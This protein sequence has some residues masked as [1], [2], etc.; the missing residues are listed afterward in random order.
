[1]AHRAPLTMDGRERVRRQFT[2]GGADRPPLIVF[3]TEF[4]ARLEQVDPDALWQ[5]A[6]LLTRTLLGLHSLFGLD[7]LVID[8]PPAALQ[9]DSLEIVDDAIGRLHVTAQG[10]ALVL[11]LPGP[12]TRGGGHVEPGNAALE[13]L[14]EELVEAARRL[15][16][17][18]TDCLAVVERA[19]IGSADVEPLEETLTPVWNTA[20]YYAT[21]SL[22]VAAQGV[23]ELGDTGADAV[24]VWAGASPEALAEQGARRVG[25]PVDSGDPETMPQLPDGGFYISRGDLAP[26]AD[27][28]SLHRLIAAVNR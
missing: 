9:R 20:R 21:S 13:E 11:A 27:I 28:D 2:R 1:M 4:A 25:W 3:A 19:A 16:A 26:D 10:V 5:D 22:L 17:E 6:N 23:P 7:A 18:R 15:G 12:L 8:V 24:A 14:G